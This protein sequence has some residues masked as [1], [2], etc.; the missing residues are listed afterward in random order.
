MIYL[1]GGGKLICLAA[2]EDV[3][4]LVVVFWQFR[5]GI[6][7]YLWAQ[8]FW[9][10]AG[11][12]ISCMHM[13]R[14]CLRRYL[15]NLRRSAC[16]RTVYGLLLVSTVFC[17]SLRYSAIA[18]VYCGGLRKSAVVCESLRWSAVVCGV[19]R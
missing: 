2:I 5:T 16:N 19:L 18:W 13:L 11:D 9:E 14:L 6:G 12:S 8:A 3:E 7:V 4:I 17:D 1:T 15:Q 10:A